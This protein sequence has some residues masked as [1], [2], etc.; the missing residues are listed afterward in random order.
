M[1]G[2]GRSTNSPVEYKRMRLVFPTWLFPSTRTLNVAATTAD[3]EG[4]LFPPLAAIGIWVCVV[5]CRGPLLASSFTCA[6]NK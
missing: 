6:Q 1:V 2:S 4:G 5:E 3:G